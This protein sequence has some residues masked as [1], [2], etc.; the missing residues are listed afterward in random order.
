MK[1]KRLTA[2]VLALLLSVSMLLQP[3]TAEAAVKGNYKVGTVYG[4]RLN[5][6]ELKQVK[7]KVTAFVKKYITSDMSDFDK[8]VACHDYL[9]NHCTYAPD[10]SKHQANTAWGALVYGQAQCSGYARA[11]K[12]LCDAAGVGCKYVHA[13]SKAK[14]PSHQWNE[15]RVDGKWYI[16][17][18]QC[19]DLSGFYAFFLV[20]GAT[21]LAGTGDSWNKKGL[22]ACKEDFDFTTQPQFDATRTWEKDPMFDKL[23]NYLNN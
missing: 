18:V 7:K 21:Y 9:C 12:A 17:D 22:P 23:M 8:V 3:V 19:N 13:N 15:V 11:M 6:K 20:S 1:G 2:F 16:V 14:A 10:W 4:P 5:S